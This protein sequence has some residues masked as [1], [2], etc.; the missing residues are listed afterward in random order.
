MGFPLVILH[1]TLIFPDK[2][3][4]KS[5]HAALR[6]IPQIGN[7]HAAGSTLQNKLF[8]HHQPKHPHS[9]LHS[10]LQPSLTGWWF[11]ATPLKNDE[12]RQLR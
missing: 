1:V 8:Q 10:N 9:N 11:L 6:G 5:R 7:P 12:L 2:N 3:I 4:Y